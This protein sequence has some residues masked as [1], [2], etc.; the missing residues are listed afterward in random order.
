MLVIGL[1]GGIGCGKSIVSNIFH[2]DFN[3]PIIDADIIARELTQTTRVSEVLYQDL[4][5]EYFDNVRTLQRDRLRQAVFSN[6]E[7]RHKLEKIL[8]PLVYEE[9]DYKLKS[10]NSDYCIVV[11]P[12]LL[13]TKRTD[14]IDRILVVDC[15]VEE[16]IHRVMLRDRCSETH[17]KAIIA[18]QIYRAE[19]LQFADDIIENHNS[20]E[21]LRAKVAILH[22]KFSTQKGATSAVVN[23]FLDSTVISYEQPLN[24]RMRTF[25]RYEQLM[26]R[27][28]LF[29]QRQEP[30]D[31]HAALMV[32]VE[33]LGLVSRGDL[34]QELLKEIKRQI[35]TL[36][37]LT[38][39]PKLNTAKL[40]NILAKHKS[41]FD[42]L[43]TSHGQL[44]SHLKN[45]AFIG[46]IRQRAIIPGGTCDFDL[47]EYHHWLT[48]A[49]TLRN[50]ILQQWVAPFEIVQ[51]G[52]T[53]VL[54]LIRES[55]PYA[56]QIAKKGLYDQRLEPSQPNQLLRIGITK[57][58]NL[59]PECS[60]GKHR[61][62]IRFLEQ[63]DPNSSAKQTHED[64][65]FK[66]A[67]CA[68]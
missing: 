11:I 34:K 50:K 40:L 19:H 20:M 10:L 63:T 51:E 22:E 16:Q 53:Q 7:I 45:N 23:S 21:S 58:D 5:A 27:F 44:G 31:S 66:L 15:T 8:H 24:E 67:C 6:P 41:I 65:E 36:K 38:N 32:L 37:P 62:S 25:L 4:G 64:T 61:F 9:I 39:K 28:R 47:P 54:Q 59:F 49:H 30:E 1:T 52:V 14:L 43:Y 2:Q 46:S 12:L 68:F 3:I 17:V 48:Q 26:Y 60:A 13:E 57:K 56:D 55:T 35:D 29:S 33:V 42:Q 18:T